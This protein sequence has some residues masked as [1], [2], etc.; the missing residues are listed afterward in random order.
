M[1]GEG[2]EQEMQ[3][4][5]QAWQIAQVSFVHSLLHRT[6]TQTLSRHHAISK[7]YPHFLRKH[8]DQVV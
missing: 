8:Q 6:V 4:T 7:G 1:N 2:W 3:D 5:R